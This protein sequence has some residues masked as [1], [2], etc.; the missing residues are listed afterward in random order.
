MARKIGLDLGDVR[1]G[2]AVSDPTGLI[3]SP[4]ETYKRQTPEKDA[5]FF[6]K[7]VTEESADEIVLGLPV[8]M[9]GTEGERAH[10]AREYGEMLKNSISSVRVGFLDERLTTVQA[11]RALISADM[12]RDKRKEVIDKVAAALILQTYLDK[13]KR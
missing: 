11:E 9:D 12:R 13:L 2:V 6:Q 10:L 7:I 1:I 4:R 8:N 5:A 3:A